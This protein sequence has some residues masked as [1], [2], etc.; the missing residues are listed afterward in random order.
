MA[1]ARSSNGDARPDHGAE[2]RGGPTYPLPQ[3]SGLSPV[4]E[5]NIRALQ[6]RREREEAEGSK[7]WARRRRMSVG[8]SRAPSAS[9]G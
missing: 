3:P 2:A 8:T 5:R 6:R 1:A 7:L 4:L 9:C